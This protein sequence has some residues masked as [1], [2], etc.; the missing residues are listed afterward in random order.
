[1]TKYKIAAIIIVLIYFFQTFFS[2]LGGIG[3]DSLSYFG[4]AADLPNPETN[5]FPLGYPVLLR[6]FF[7]VFHDYFWASKILNLL[8]IVIILVFSYVK[9]FYFRETLLL[10]MGKTF[11]TVFIG[12]ASETLFMFL[13]YFLFFLFH[14]LLSK[15][16]N[17]YSYALGISLCLTGLLVTRYSGIY[18]YASILVFFGL[19]FFKIRDKIYF[20]PMIVMLHISAV[21]IGGYLLFN[22]MY[23][24]DYT[25]ER[26]RG[27][28]S[29]M[30]L[31]YIV[32]DVFGVMNSVDPYIGIKPASNSSVSLLFQ[33]MIFLLDV[34]IFFYFLKYY[35][36]A[37]VS[38]HYYFHLVLWV[39]AGVSG[40]SVLVSGWFQQIEEMG[41][42]LM[43][44]SN[45]CIFFSLLILYFQNQLS[46]KWIWRVSCFFLIFL[47]CYSL[48]DPGNYLENK[49]QIEP[50]MGRFKDK[51]YL[52]NDE[53][54]KVTVTTY[55]FPIIDEKFDYKH[56]NSQKG[57]LKETIAGTINPK[58]KWLKDDTVQDKTKV[59]YTSQ[60]IFK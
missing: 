30:T 47:T 45:F 18:I 43:A 26:L 12:A 54:N 21:G 42:R 23:F 24:G 3:A 6:I 22:V 11:F 53:K 14:Q 25:G 60:L 37:K 10:F 36:K 9:K 27:K 33:F 16:D 50:Q 58:I 2:S 46:D 19:M 28:P 5:L 44:A 8:L 48:K 31:V 29:S 39:V 32:R 56:T 49:K 1:M 40:I 4:I 41:V 52:Y 35:K 57:S 59:L 20:K 7:T 34:G 51:K 38:Q 55:H 17:L 15:K 13:L